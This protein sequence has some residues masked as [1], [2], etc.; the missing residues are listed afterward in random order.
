[1]KAPACYKESRQEELLV[2]RRGT[3]RTRSGWIAPLPPIPGQPAYSAPASSS[4]HSF[5][6][7][8]FL[9]DLVIPFCEH[10]PRSEMIHW[11]QRA[12]CL[13]SLRTE[14]SIACRCS[15]STPG[16][17]RGQQAHRRES[18]H[19]DD[20]G[21][22][23]A[24]GLLPQAPLPS[25]TILIAADAVT[26]PPLLQEEPKPASLQGYCS[27][28]HPRSINLNVLEGNRTRH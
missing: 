1:M 21:F 22:R 23:R 8:T 17:A 28:N 5:M 2:R 24:E 6:S 12:H 9:Y 16:K 25:T 18:C 13:S 3:T 4:H 11:W 19:G 15:G 27:S 14:P 26:L 7:A 20:S 10:I